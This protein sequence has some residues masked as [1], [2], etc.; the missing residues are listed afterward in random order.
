M[1]LLRSLAPGLVLAALATAAAPLA[2]QR[3]PAFAVAMLRRDGVIIPFAVFDGRSWSTPWPAPTYGLEAPLTM[4]AVKRQSEL[5][6][7][8][9]SVILASTFCRWYGCHGT[10][11]KR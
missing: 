6:G 9:H 1:G 10:S 2:A 3:D 11:T 5:R 4:A 8:R 7:L